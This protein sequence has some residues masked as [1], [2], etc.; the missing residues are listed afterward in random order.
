MFC[1]PESPRIPDR[2][3]DVGVETAR[4]ATGVATACVDRAVE[5]RAVGSPVTVVAG[6]R[7]EPAAVGGGET[8]SSNPP[9]GSS[10]AAVRGV[11]T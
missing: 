3:R 11:G 2:G 5:A 10:A 4:D 6:F 8:G 7:A 1:C 9:A